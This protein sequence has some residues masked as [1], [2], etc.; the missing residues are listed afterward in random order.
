VRVICPPERN[1][2]KPWPKRLRRWV[3]GLRQIGETVHEKLLNAFGLG[4]GQPHH[5]TGF[6]ARSAARVPP[7]NFC[8]WLNQ[9][10]G[11]PQLAFAD[12]LE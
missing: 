1:I 8:I 9:C 6:Q 11:S 3:A 5:I 7:H 10:L 4:P 12:L 2:L